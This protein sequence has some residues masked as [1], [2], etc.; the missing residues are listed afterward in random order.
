MKFAFRWSE[1]AALLSWAVLL[2]KHAA[3]R[4]AEC[5]KGDEAALRRVELLRV[6]YF[7]GVS[8]D[9]LAG[10]WHQ[11]AEKTKADFAAARDEF[12]KALLEVL[13][14]NHPKPHEEAVAE[15]AELYELL[16]NGR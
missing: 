14:F 8:I 1:R 4:Q 5:A 7:G 13:V 11:G 9:E 6:H 10:N 12:E 16:S 2:A 15:R 3:A